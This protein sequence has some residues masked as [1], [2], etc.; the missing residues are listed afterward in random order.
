MLSSFVERHP[1]GAIYV[2]VGGMH[3]S[4]ITKGKF[5]CCILA[6]WCRC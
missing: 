3:G 6:G 4:R 5:A 2:S 1:L